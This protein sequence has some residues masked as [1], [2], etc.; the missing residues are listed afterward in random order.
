MLPYISVIV[1]FVFK[2]VSFFGFNPFP[3]QLPTVTTDNSKNFQCANFS[4][5]SFGASIDADILQPL[6]LSYTK[7]V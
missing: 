1:L 2:T 6:L 7:I 4:G 5:H 3:S